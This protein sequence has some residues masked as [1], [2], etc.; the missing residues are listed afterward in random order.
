MRGHNPLFAYNFAPNDVIE[1]DAVI[2]L[3][4]RFL[5]G[6]LWISLN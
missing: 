2:R 4:R 3:H 1:V 6:K 5:G